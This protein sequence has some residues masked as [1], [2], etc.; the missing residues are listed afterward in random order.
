NSFSGSGDG[1]IFLGHLSKAAADYFNTNF[2]TNYHSEA[3]SITLANNDFSNWTGA[4]ILTFDASYTLANGGAGQTLTSTVAANGKETDTLTGFVSGDQINL[5]HDVTAT[6]VQQ[7]GKS[8][9]NVSLSNGDQLVF[10]GDGIK[11]KEV[12]AALGV[13]T[14]VDNGNHNGF[15]HSQ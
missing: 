6:S 2:G 13:D 4:D 10:Q 3:G 15:G 8:E 12:A 14:H 1:A 5:R 11:A 7:H 9:V